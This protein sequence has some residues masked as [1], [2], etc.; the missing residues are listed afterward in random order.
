MDT[1]PGSA[2]IDDARV[3]GENL[4]RIDAK[5]RPG[6]LHEIGDEHVRLVHK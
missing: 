4:L 5:L 1:V 6:R 3:A 2:A